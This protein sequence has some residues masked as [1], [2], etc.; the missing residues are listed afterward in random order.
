MND[1]TYV[2]IY[3]DADGVP[4]AWGSGSSEPEAR[5]RA[6]MELADYIRE[7]VGT[8]L[9]AYRSPFKVTV[10]IK[11]RSTA[12]HASLMTEW[13]GDL[14]ERLYAILRTKSR[15]DLAEFMVLALTD[16]EI[17]SLARSYEVCK[18]G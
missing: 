11:E 12:L 10:R 3:K 7:N 9:P 8:E 1:L 6:C 5:E 13:K 2:A 16:A 18:R 17:L 15:E 14:L 4:R